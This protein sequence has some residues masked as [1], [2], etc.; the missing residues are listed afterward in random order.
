MI[1]ESAAGVTKALASVWPMTRLALLVLTV[2]RAEVAT[3]FSSET[4]A[5]VGRDK[6]AHARSPDHESQA[7]QDC[8][9]EP[10]AAKGLDATLEDWEQRFDWKEQAW[11]AASLSCF[12]RAQAHDHLLRHLNTSLSRA[13]ASNLYSAY[14]LAPNAPHCGVTEHCAVLR[15]PHDFVAD[16]RSMM[17]PAEQALTTRTLVAIRLRCKVT[18]VAAFP[19]GASRAFGF[20]VSKM[21]RI[22]KELQKLRPLA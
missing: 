9:S 15:Q 8:S 21:Q 12:A 18:G 17:A 20:D 3:V 14:T 10:L 16:T 2:V 22:V 19:G 4:A 11:A 7:P 1:K 13:E 6:L 5:V